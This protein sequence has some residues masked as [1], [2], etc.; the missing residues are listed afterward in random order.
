[1][2]RDTYNPEVKN[3]FVNVL[4]EAEQVLAEVQSPQTTS[5]SSLAG[6]GSENGVCG[7]FIR[8]GRQAGCGTPCCWILHTIGVFLSVA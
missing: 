8:L 4:D 1:M 6:N 5:N 7:C 3:L 2:R